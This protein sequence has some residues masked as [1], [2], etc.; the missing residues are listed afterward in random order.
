MEKEP[1]RVLTPFQC[2]GTKKKKKKK[3]WEPQREREYHLK[4]SFFPVSFLSFFFFG[5]CNKIISFN[6][7]DKIMKKEP[8]GMLTPF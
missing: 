7:N 2:D 3:N 5:V 4:V 8:V 6:L 1:V